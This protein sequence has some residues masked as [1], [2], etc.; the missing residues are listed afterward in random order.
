MQS[1]PA[2]KKADIGRNRL[3]FD[4]GRDHEST[5]KQIIPALR[6][7]KIGG[8]RGRCQQNGN[9]QQNEKVNRNE[10]V[11]KSIT[12]K[13]E[14]PIQAQVC[15]HHMASLSNFQLKSFKCNVI[16]LLHEYVHVDIDL[17]PMRSDLLLMRF[18]AIFRSFRTRSCFRTRVNGPSPPCSFP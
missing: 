12:G 15:A 16:D 1:E 4:S 13:K 10:Q 8:R 17:C 7:K 11:N 2:G 9:G 18:V 5:K 14:Q 3:L 6:G